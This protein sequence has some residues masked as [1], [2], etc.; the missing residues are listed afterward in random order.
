LQLGFLASYLAVI[1]GFSCACVVHEN[2]YPM[3]GRQMVVLCI[4]IYFKFLIFRFN[5]RFEH[6]HVS[7]LIFWSFLCFVSFKVVH[8]TI[9]IQFKRLIIFYGLDNQLFVIKGGF[10]MAKQY[11][12]LYFS[13]ITI[14]QD[15]K[16]S[17]SLNR[18]ALLF[19]TL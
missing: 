17:R 15:N 8:S 6:S 11:L 4:L 3:K 9:Y 12:N 10:L 5:S 14:G 18:A 2:N 1:A 16:K 13:G 19:Y 7:G